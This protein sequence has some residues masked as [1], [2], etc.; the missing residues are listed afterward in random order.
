MGIKQRRLQNLRRRMRAK[1]LP[2][3][4]G[5]RRL[6]FGEGAPDA[7]V[8]FIGEAP[9]R[10][11]DESGRPFVGLAGRELTRLI[12][13]AGLRREDVY[14]TSV[15]KYRP[16]KNRNPRQ[17]EI[18]AHAPYLIDQI[19]IICPQKLVT[20]GNFATKFILSHFRGVSP[21]EVPDIS[22]CRGTACDISIAGRRVTV[23]PVYHPA[24]VLYNRGLAGVLASDFLLITLPGEIRQKKGGRNPVFGGSRRPPPKS[25]F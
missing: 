5:A 14:I 9:G 12:A 1:P 16:P 19:R 23:M 3:K 10:K 4:K 24:A 17:S 2:L 18:E 25:F 21:K 6:V 7:S 8:M 20:L 13:H 15:L 11:E 22:L